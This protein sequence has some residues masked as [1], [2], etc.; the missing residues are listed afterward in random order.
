M[1]SVLNVT[2]ME[3]WEIV[4]KMAKTSYRLVIYMWEISLQVRFNPSV[5]SKATDSLSI[6]F[7]QLYGLMQQAFSMTKTILSTISGESYIRSVRFGYENTNSLDN[8]SGIKRV[9]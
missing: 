9:N 6:C 2:H 8:A 7:L 1:R 3:L 4:K 5:Q